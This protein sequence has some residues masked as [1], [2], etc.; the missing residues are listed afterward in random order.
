VESWNKTAPAPTLPPDV[1]ANTGAKYREAVLA[2]T[3]KSLE[4]V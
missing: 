1:I 4:A 2:L 3:G